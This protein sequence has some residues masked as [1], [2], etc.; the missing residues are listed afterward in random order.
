MAIARVQSKTANTA[1]SAATSLTI[2]LGSNA[3]IGNTLLI[4]FVAAVSIPTRF[5]FGSNTEV[6]FATFG[7]NN[8]TM[9]YAFVPVQE[10]SNSIVITFSSSL[11]AAVAVEYSGRLI[12]CDL[13]ILSNSNAGSTSNATG[14]TA[15]SNYANELAVAIMATRFAT[16]TEQT[17]WLASITN[18]FTSVAQTSSN[19]NTSGDREIA[20]LEKIVSSTGTFQTT[21]TQSNAQWANMIATFTEP[22][23]GGVLINPGMSGGLR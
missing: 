20:F 12:A 14:T 3:T 13:P 16:T 10:A 22:S 5:K 15:T 6:P 2:T 8:V 17:A 1:G 7:A 23:S 19:A 11:A 18:S 4:G 21:G 9:A